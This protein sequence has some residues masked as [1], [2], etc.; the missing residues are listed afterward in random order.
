MTT[1]R[2]FAPSMAEVTL[3][4][5]DGTERTGHLTRF[6]PLVPDIAL[7]LGAARDG[8]GMVG[9]EK[10]AFV[11]FHKQGGDAPPPPSMRRG[12]LKVHAVGKRTFLVMPMEGA[13]PGTIGFYAKPVEPN[14][15]FRELFFY[16][17]G[18][19]LKELNEPLGAMLVR[20]GHLRKTALDKGL[21]AQKDQPRTPI[22]Q[23]LIEQQKLDDRRLAQATELQQRRGAR[24][25]EVLIEAG[26]ATP[27]DI[28]LALVEQRKRT[29]KRIGQILVD[30]KLISE[31]DL[32]ATLARKFQLPFIDLDACAIDLTSVGELPKEFI[33]KHKLL[34]VGTEPRALTVAL[35]DPLAVDAIDQARMLAKKQISEV[36][37]TPS[38]LERYIP[39]TLSAAA[40][41]AHKSEMDAILRNLESDEGVAGADLSEGPETTS[42][43]E[44]DNAIIKLANQIIIDAYRQGASDIHIEP[45][46]KER[47]TVVRFRVDGECGTYESAGVDAVASRRGVTT[48]RWTLDQTTQAL[49]RRSVS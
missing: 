9:A 22:G 18:V 42:V 10:V 16:N 5:M 48:L 36:V 27:Q 17:H 21:A 38:Q 24:L 1:E 23:I 26:L 30:L 19:I 13:E 47:G 41:A 20:E 2:S 29:G 25:G 28:E 49:R 39:S 40:A 12:I 44:S 34:P 11:G 8:T 33:E 6:V 46:G 35:A 37:V 31:R 45:N 32:S 43:T 4:M 15:P 3:G 7:S 14:S